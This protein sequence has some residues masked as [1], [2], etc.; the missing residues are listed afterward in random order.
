MGKDSPN[1]VIDFACAYVKG[2]TDRITNGCTLV[3]VVV[4]IICMLFVLFACSIE[5]YPYFV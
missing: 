2:D 3:Y 4:F 1:P 5:S